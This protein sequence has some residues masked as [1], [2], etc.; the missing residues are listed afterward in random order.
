MTP[1]QKE[2]NL[3]KIYAMEVL[4]D[5]NI[6]LRLKNANDYTKVKMKDYDKNVQDYR[7][8]YD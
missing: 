7:A 5:E 3:K 6:W 1:A 4:N 2:E 8:Q